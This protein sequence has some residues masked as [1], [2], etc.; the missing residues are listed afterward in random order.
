MGYSNDGKSFSPDDTDTI[1]YLY[2]SI[3]LLDLQERIKEWWPKANIN[4]IHISS[5]HIHTNAI[6]YD[7]YD[8]SDYTLYLVIEYIKETTCILCDQNIEHSNCDSGY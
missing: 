4:E 3:T 6:G 5:E 1:K 8:S 2:N 7:L